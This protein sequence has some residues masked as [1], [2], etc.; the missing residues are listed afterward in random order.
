M[1]NGLI[2]FNHYNEVGAMIKA[3]IKCPSIT[4]KNIRYDEALWGDCGTKYICI[5]S[6]IKNYNHC[7]DGV[8]VVDQRLSYYITDISCYQ[9]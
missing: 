3:N 8:D 9:N 1:D 4:M 5:L 7:M 2:F 6:L